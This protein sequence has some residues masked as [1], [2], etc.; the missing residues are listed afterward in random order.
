MREGSLVLNSWRVE[1]RPGDWEVCTIEWS[2]GADPTCG[3]G[4]VFPG[5][6]GDGYNLG[7]LAGT[8]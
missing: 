5:V 7:P 6:V 3:I 1:L 4:E 2:A 8:R